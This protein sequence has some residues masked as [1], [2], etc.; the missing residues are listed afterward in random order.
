MKIAILTDKSRAALLTGKEGYA[1]DLQKK[2]TVLELKEVLTKKFDCIT[3][4]ADTTLISKL[5][6]ENVDLVFNL[7]NGLIGS[8]KQAQVPAILEFAG[9]PYTGS[10][11]LGHAL[12]IN[13]NYSC[14]IFKSLGIPTP[15]FISIYSEKDLQKIDYSR[16][17]FPLLVKPCDEGSGRGIQQNSLVFN[18]ADLKK[19]I[20]EKLAKYNPPIMINEYIKGREFTVGILGNKDKLKVLPILEI[21]FDNLPKHLARFY[22]FEVK[23]KYGDQTVYKCPAPLD[24]ELQCRIE[25]T[26]KRAYNALNMRDYARVDIRLKDKIPYV[27]EINS[28]PG[29]QRKYSDITKMADACGLGYEG[30]VFQIVKNALNRYDYKF[31]DLSAV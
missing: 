12:A 3:L 16:L 11:V 30:L 2:Q 17:S 29:L 27:L 19:R 15:R 20:R 31:E 24:K 1:E 13:K 9:I 10:S 8:S 25:K 7:S 26:A 6:K 23:S 4:K 5:R 28:L 18:K 22:S 14:K 21:G